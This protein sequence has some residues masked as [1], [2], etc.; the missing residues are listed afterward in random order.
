M[1]KGPGII[2][3]F[4]QIVF[5][6][7]SA[8]KASQQMASALGGAGKKAGENF[9]RE[10]RE[11]FD[12]RMAELRVKLAAGIIDQR[13]FKKQA[14]LA[15]KTFNQGIVKG[16][17]EAH[18]AGTLTDKEFL[19]LSRTLKKTGDEG[20]FAGSR[21]QTAFARLGTFLA[22]TF[23]ID[24]AIR[25]FKASIDAA[26]QA[27]ES[28]ARL[29]AALR[30]LGM[31]YRTVSREVERYFERIQATTRFNDDDAREA[32]GNLI[33]ATGDYNLSL[34]LLNLTANIAEH[35]HTTMAE[36]AKVAADAS[37]GLTRGMRDLGINAKETGDIVAKLETNLNGLA[38][39]AGGTNAGKLIRANN[40]WGEF[41]EKIGAAILG[42]EGL[43]E[44][45]G[46][47][48]TR[49]VEMNHWA[50]KNADTIGRLVDNILDL[51]SATAKTIGIL[52]RLT[53]VRDAFR[54]GRDLVKGEPELPVAPGIEVTKPGSPLTRTRQP[55][56]TSTE[57]SKEAKKALR[58]RESLEHDIRVATL[59]LEEQLTRDLAQEMVRRQEVLGNAAQMQ[60]GTMEEGF[61]KLDQLNLML[62]VAG[63]DRTL[64]P[65]VQR[66]EQAFQTLPPVMETMAAGMEKVAEA[67]EFNAA[68]FSTPWI[69][70]M[71][72]IR[73]EVEG[74][75]TLF[76]ELGQA[77]ADGG[78]KGIVELAKHK[79]KENLAFVI[80][81]LAK[82]FG[83]LGLGNP[84]SAT[85]HFKAAAQ[86]GVAAVAWKALSAAGG[87]G[88]SGSA[89]AGGA[90]GGGGI[91]AAS[92]LERPDSAINIYLTGPGWNAL[93]PAVQKVVHQAGEIARERY[94]SNSKVRIVRGNP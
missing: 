88:G 34:R 12:R 6:R 3:R 9:V 60:F 66:T 58:D 8:Q 85:L 26:L 54:L 70:A 28:V 55:S 23:T 22:A 27:E 11:A 36:A 63:F 48:I 43:Q 89:A 14:D 77:W 64:I 92:R 15:A 45:S 67:A 19:K 83:S 94:G 17:K 61:K 93:N 57:P 24:R 56:T 47:L 81:N 90:G 4:I 33:T 73:N 65:Q 40:L 2:R 7:G 79:V 87:G 38:E 75:G 10:L 74:Q 72:V 20:A 46:R 49:L 18:K 39:A 32:F 16:M 82:A 53:N 71:G 41:Q 13:E 42:S 50:D 68:R 25:F 62:Q 91:T 52:A 35:R 1:A 37:K 51:V 78:F 84:A 5:D 76:A 31:E 86:H 21:I 59:M 80:E 30:P 69:D 44:S 29:A